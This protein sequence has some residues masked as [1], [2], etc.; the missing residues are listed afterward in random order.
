MNTIRLGVA[1]LALALAGCAHHAHMARKPSVDKYK[2]DVT[3]A[4]GE[5]DAPESLY[6]RKGEKGVITWHLKAKDYRF[7]TDGIVFQSNAAG[8]I[9]NCGRAKDNDKLFSCDN[10]HRKEG[11]GFFYKYAIKVEPNPGSGAPAVPVL[12]PFVLND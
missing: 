7:A 9:V 11:Q 12:D 5:I 3:V 10:L 2:P 4:G 6:F 1:A 8:E